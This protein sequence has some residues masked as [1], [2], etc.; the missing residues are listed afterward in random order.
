IA[1][2]ANNFGKMGKKPTH[3][4]LLDFLASYLTEHNWSTKAVHKL[5]LMS[6]TYRL[7]S[8]HADQKT[9]DKVDP[10]NNSWVRF[11]PRRLSAEE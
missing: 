1:E 5:I 7:S 3:P 9:L 4:E 8:Q 10:D 6:H 2:N 11:N